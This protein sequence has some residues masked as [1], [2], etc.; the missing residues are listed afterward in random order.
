MK[1]SRLLPALLLLP[2]GFGLADVQLPAI[3]SDH[4]VLEK[5]ARVPIWGTADPGEEVSVSLAGQ[6]VKTTAGPDGKW[7]VNLNLSESAP[8]PLQ[9][10]VQ[11]K[12]TLTIDDVLVG[13]VWV[14]SGQSNMAWTLANTLGA[15]EEIARSANPHLR[16]FV[17]PRNPTKDPQDNCGGS[18]VTASPE[19]AGAFTAVGYYFGKT[20]QKDLQTPVGLINTSVGGTPS[21]AWTSA[22]ALDS[23]P[24]LKAGKDRIHSIIQNHPELQ[25][26]W[27][28]DF[29][30]WLKKTDREDRPTADVSAFAAPDVSTDG[31]VPVKLPGSLSGPGLPAAGAIWLRRTV[32]IPEKAAGSKM[33][34]NLGA[35]QGFDST[36]W[37]GHLIKHLTYDKYPGTGFLRRFGE[38]TIP[39]ELVKAGPNTLAIRI[40]EPVNAPEFANPP[41]VGEI[42]LAG[43][44]LAKP[45]FALPALDKT[46][47]A[48]V[49]A[50]P[51]NPPNP[52]NVPT[53]LFNGMIHP[54]VPY[55]ISG[56]IW[57]QGESNAGRAWQYRT[58][59]PL[60]I[61]DWRTQWNQGDFPF[62]FAQLANYQAK[63]DTP[64]ESS[65]AELREA[66][67]ATLSL[68][69]TGQAILIDIGESG[70]IHP[71]NKKDVG[72]RLAKIALARDY[73]KSLPYSGPVFKSATVEDGKIRLSFSHT[74]GGLRAAPLPETYDVHTGSKKTAPLVRNSPASELEG[75][76]ICGEDRQW[77]WAE[78]KIDGETVLIWSDKIPAPVAVRYAWA[79]NPTC[80][81]V[82]GAGLPASPFRTDTFPAATLGNKL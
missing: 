21:E 5:A 72:E 66:Q 11:G 27:V 3:I 58:A 68:P 55:A 53:Y 22:E 24:E 18:W 8:G 59:F 19:T 77:V 25:K 64:A 74:D 44:W 26:K 13:E 73:G 42:S 46:A 50:P 23:V 75:F 6:T 17:V 49:P 48:A 57:Y 40:Y 41:K 47:L 63:K 34:L 36:Y 28:Q 67:S 76:A 45:E 12:N 60:M 2:F 35:I 9:M 7:R 78:A 80:N 16:Q 31:W 1:T 65:W 82:N 37:N 33:G 32:D 30:A 51:K 71:R 54:I 79:D 69:H 61:T 38:Y 56:V 39:G 29:A 14:A 15:A 4:M 10:T 81:L 52:Q 20:L 43:Q 62:Y 70:D